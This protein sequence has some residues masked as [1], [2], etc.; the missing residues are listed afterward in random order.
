M[1]SHEI[2]S[3]AN[4]FLGLVNTGVDPRTGQFMLAMSLPLAPAN[5][6]A[7]PSLTPTLSF[8]SLSSARN[9]GFGLGWSLNLSELNL[10]PEAPTLRLTSGEQ[11]A[12]DW[13]QSDL[14]NGGRLVFLDHKLESMVV[15]R[16]TEDCF[17]VVMKSG[18]SELLTR[19]EDD[20]YR[21]TEVRSAEGR[22][23]FID[24][25]P[26]GEGQSIVETF[27]DENRTLMRVISEQDEIKLIANP[28][29]PGASTSLRLLLSNERLSDVYLPGIDEPFSFS[30]EAHQV[31]D[32]IELLFPEA[33]FGPLGAWDTVQWAIGDEGHRMPVGA[34]FLF[35]PRVA[36]WTHSSSE[37]GCELY[38][39]YQWIGDHNFL[40]FGSDQGFNW[41]QG[42]DNLYQVERGYEYEGVET[43][44]DNE[45]RLLGTLTRTWNRF[46]LQT[47]EIAR[48]GSCEMRTDTT[49]GIDPDLTW[50]QQPAGCQ[51][52]QTIRTTYIDHDRAGTWRS[53]QT[54]YRYDEYGNVLHVRYPTGVEEHSEYYPA[55]GADGCPADASGMVKY[56][57]SKTVTPAAMAT[58]G[59]N[60]AA[61]VSV[62]YTYEPLESLLADGMP[63]AVVSSEQARDVTHD[64]VLETTRQRYVL[65]RDAHYGR[66]A[67]SI[68]TLNGKDTRT[69]YRYEI[70]DSELITHVTVNGFEN[71]AESRASSS[72]AQS[73][74]TGLTSWELNAEGMRTGYE[75]DA[76]GRIVRTT[77]A[78]GSAC[79]A[80]R[81]ARY[82]VRN[83]LATALTLD[84][85]ANPVLLEQS[86]V[87]GQRRRNWL[88]GSGRTVRIELEDLDHTPG[89]FREIA[90]IR[91]DAQGRTISQ[92]SLDWL[93]GQPRPLML[94]TLTHYDDWGN[95]AQVR[96]PDGVVAHRRHDPVLQRT[97]QW[98]QS[99]SRRGPRTVTL[100]NI[101]G[102]P[103]EHQL[104]DETDQWVRTTALIRD[105]LDRVIEERVKIEARADIVTRSC[106]DPYG[107]VVERQLPDGT[108]IHWTYAPHSDADHPE[109]VTVTPAKEAHA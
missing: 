27:R 83:A 70:Q 17:R 95:V 40:G 53:E 15:T 13:E 79:E 52:P 2:H 26:Y 78:Q 18:E 104:Y 88:D 35:L 39:T 54:D 103:I 68:N 38:R 72:S 7:G 23:V 16:I 44:R 21:L 50:E 34:P 24:W 86:D 33:L 97:E 96:G 61:V 107:R 92:S 89:V 49:Y 108:L 76:M 101:A 69:T 102:S 55:Q 12:V 47:Q 9:T 62:T 36:G 82:H 4:N 5:N 66:D 25:L 29:T 11:F 42:R 56:L 43:Q 99:P 51:L 59:L 48:R 14:S 10:N 30:Y 41:Q 74:F 63:H 58:D 87:T 28:D 94:T 75:Y 32:G 77:G 57:K 45:G 6:L 1:S 73:L 85:R 31:S 60:N 22:R 80:V 84:Q 64:R 93:P 65:T 109:S 67:E 3:Q 71:T 91:Y 20:L 90:R 37:T 100:T 105:G 98:Q 46:H 8:S 81:T 106:L 19:Q